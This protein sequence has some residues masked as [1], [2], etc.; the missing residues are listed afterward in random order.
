MENFAFKKVW[1]I[2]NDRLTFYFNCIP[3]NEILD[4]SKSKT[5]VDNKSNVV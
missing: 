2:F 3:N 5:V 4:L 1:Q